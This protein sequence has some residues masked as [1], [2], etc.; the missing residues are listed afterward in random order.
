[1]QIIQHFSG[2][3]DG[4]SKSFKVGIPDQ[5]GRMTVERSGAYI[6]NGGTAPPISLVVP[7]PDLTIGGPGDSVVHAK[8]AGEGGEFAVLMIANH[9]SA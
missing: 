9:P 6:V 5:A 1:M 3:E 8:T 4:R 2:K 7:A